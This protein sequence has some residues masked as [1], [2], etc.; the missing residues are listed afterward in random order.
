MGKVKPLNTRVDDILT[1]ETISEFT[2]SAVRGK[3]EVIRDALQLIALEVEKN[4]IRI[5]VNLK[6]GIE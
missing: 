6:K 5:E 4:R 3:F 2:T 1:G